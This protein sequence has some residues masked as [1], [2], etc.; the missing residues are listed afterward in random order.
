MFMI[1]KEKQHAKYLIC[2]KKREI[3]PWAKK[4]D[5]CTKKYKEVVKKIIWGEYIYDSEKWT[6]PHLHCTLHLWSEML[7]K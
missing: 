3:D 2:D 4:V 6:S 5:P 7:M 1:R